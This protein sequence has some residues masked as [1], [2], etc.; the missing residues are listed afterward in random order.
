[1]NKNKNKPAGAKAIQM[2]GAETLIKAIFTG[3]DMEV[4]QANIQELS[5]SGRLGN[6]DSLAIR[7]ETA[8]KRAEDREEAEKSA[9]GT[10]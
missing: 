7:I 3:R 4:I 10:E 6:A 8:I 2:P 1:M 5:Q 9:P